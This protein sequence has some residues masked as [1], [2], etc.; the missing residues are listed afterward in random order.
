VG[1]PGLE[2]CTTNPTH[3]NFEGQL[4][5]P[6]DNRI[7]EVPWTT[8]LQ[9]EWRQNMKKVGDAPETVHGAVESAVTQAHRDGYFMTGGILQKFAP[10]MAKTVV[11]VSSFRSLEDLQKRTVVRR[12][13][14]KRFAAEDLMAVLGFQLFVPHDPDRNDFDL[15]SEAAETASDADYRTKRTALYLWQQQFIRNGF[16]DALSIRTA[17]DQMQMLVNNLDLQNRWTWVK[18][19][20]SFFRLGADVAKVAAPFAAESASAV[21]SVGDFVV[22]QALA[23][24]EP[25]LLGKPAAAPIL[26][27]QQ[28]L[29]LKMNENGQVS[30]KSSED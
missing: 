6:N 25:N 30:L 7:I 15:L 1:V 24:K 12:A 14:P 19:V 20:L 23:D 21:L 9:N 10:S 27:A 18:Q 17:V 29:G 16:T 2:P 13:P 22:D 11:A 8:D 5:K 4:N 3:W 28:R 26:D